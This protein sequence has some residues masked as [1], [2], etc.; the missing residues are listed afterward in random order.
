MPFF[1]FAIEIYLKS[2]SVLKFSVSFSPTEPDSGFE[3]NTIIAASV[4]TCT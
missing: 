4:L 2:V 1:I 3:N